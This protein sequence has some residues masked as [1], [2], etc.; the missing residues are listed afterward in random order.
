MSLNGPGPDRAATFLGT[1]GIALLATVAKA[2][3]SILPVTGDDLDGQELGR[4]T[5]VDQGDPEFSNGLG[6]GFSASGDRVEP[7]F[8]FAA[9]DLVRGDGVAFARLRISSLGGSMVGNLPVDVVG[10]EA[11]EAIPFGPDQRPSQF[12]ST[13]T[14]VPWDQ[15]TAWL[16]GA[17]TDPMFEFSPDLSPVLNELLASECW[18]ESGGSGSF[19][20]SLRVEGAGSG[21]FQSMADFGEGWPP[22]QLEIYSRVVDAFLAPPLLGRATDT[23]V[24]LSFAHFLT[25][26]GYVAYGVAPGQYQWA[27]G[28][29]P[30]TLPDVHPFLDAEAG[31]VRE[32][33]ITG[34]EPNQRYYGALFVRKSGTLEY[35]A[36][37]EFSFQTQRPAGASFRFDILSDSHLEDKVDAHRTD[38]IA[39]HDVSLRNVVFDD[40]DFVVHLGDFAIIRQYAAAVRTAGEARRIYS[41]L[42]TGFGTAGL[43]LPFYLVLGN[44][45]GELGWDDDGGEELPFAWGTRARKEFFPNP[46]PGSFYSG[47]ADLDPRFGRLQDYYAWTWGDALFVVLDPFRYTTTKPHGLGGPGS[48]DGWDWTL[49]IAQYDWLASVLSG[50]DARWKFVFTHHLVGGVEDPVW[51]PY[52]RGGIEGV[53]YSVE[54]RPSYEWGGEDVDG[55][56]QFEAKRPGFLHGDIHSMLVENGVSA[57]FHGHDHL[58]AHQEID[59]IV[60]QEC[61]MPSDANYGVGFLASGR[62]LSGVR[63][64]CS[65]HL[66]VDVSE[67][68]IRVAYVRAFLP[69]DGTNREVAYSYDIGNPTAGSPEWAG[70]AADGADPTRY[71]AIGPVPARE[72]LRVQARRATSLAAE[73]TLIDVSGRVVRSFLAPPMAAGSYMEWPLQTGSGVRLARGVYRLQVRIGNESEV[74]P[75]VVVE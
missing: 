27:Q 45:E 35:V 54:G 67:E 19:A 63:F 50:S 53:R 38:D 20:I 43:S 59:G 41:D 62:Y 72:T 73:V 25:T 18:P 16:G 42:R 29:L 75:L 46:E 64:P 23:S 32:V 74:H 56:Y 71:L 11:C 55:S 26:D 10:I 49:G 7:A 3:V 47:N 17:A 30:S 2:G 68:G 21:R 37:P 39:L 13:A 48:Q 52:G 24:T 66:R 28:E 9:P 15:T 5:W 70:D 36:T 33:L 58:F 34:L 65:G 31:V 69:G 1:L 51:G 60:Y 57:V 12:A 40:P 44:H 22:V 8:Q 6:L 14:F 61:P 4:S